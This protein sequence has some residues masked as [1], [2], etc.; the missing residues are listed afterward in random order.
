MEKPKT[1]I[2]KKKPTIQEKIVKVRRRA[3][4]LSTSSESLKSTAAPFLA[5]S[6]FPNKLSKNSMLVIRKTEILMTKGKREVFNGHFKAVMATP[7]EITNMQK[8]IKFLPL[9][10]VRFT[11]ILLSES[12]LNKGIERKSHSNQKKDDDF[13]SD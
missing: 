13:R 2:R 12:L 10:L 7:A 8:F 1:T 4:P 6:S 5:T 9:N 11:N 3:T